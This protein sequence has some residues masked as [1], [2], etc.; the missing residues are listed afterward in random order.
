MTEKRNV[1]INHDVKIL[2]KYYSLV[3]TGR[4]TAE[5]RK[6]DRDY[7][8]GDYLKLHEFD[9]LMYTGRV[10]TCRITHVLIDEEYVKEGFCVLSFQI[11]T[12][13]Q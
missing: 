13:H 10:V 12:P 4:K 3:I 5:V 2:P 7:R 11:L 1:A 6:N 8:E 9:G